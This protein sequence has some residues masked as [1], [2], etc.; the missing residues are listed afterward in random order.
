MH[1]ARLKLCPFIASSVVAV[2]FVAIAA[3]DARSSPTCPLS[4]GSTDAAKSHKLYLYF[5]TAPDSTFPNYGTNVSPA[6]AFNVA[7]LTSSIGTTAALRNRIFDVVSDDYCELNVQV[8]STT[9]NPANLASPPPRRAT[10][11]V[12]SDSNSNPTTGTTWG[13]AQ[14]TDTGDAVN[15]DFAR[16]WAGSYTVCEGSNPSGGCTTGSLTGSNATLDRW[17]QA[18]GGTSA[19][20]A[21]HTY[22]L[23]HTDDN[24]TTDSM[25][26]GPTPLA[27]EDSFHRHLMPSGNNLT[28]EDRASFRRHFSDRTFGLLATNVGLSIQTMHNWDLINSNAAA[29]RRLRIDF[30]SPLPSVNVAWTWT[31]A[32]SPWIAPTVS[33]PLGTSVFQGTTYNRF[34]ITWSTANPAWTGGS[35]GTVPGGGRFH[36]GATFT[37][38]DFNQPDPIIIQDITLLDAS[39]NPLILHP[40]LPIYDAGTVD[41]SDGTF[42]VNFAPPAGGGQLLIESAV[43][44]QLP[45]VASIQSMTGLGRPLTF[46]KAQIRPWS[47]STCRIK[48]LREKARCVIA[49]LTAKPHV[50]VVHRLG[51]KG[52]YDCSHGVPKVRHPAAAASSSD[53]QKP[54]DYEGPI[55]AGTQRDPF[56]STTVYM[57]VTVV[58][59]HAKYYDR[60]RKKYVVGRVT[61]KIYYQFAGIRHLV[62]RRS[63][64]ADNDSSSALVGPT[65]AFAVALLGLLLA[66]GLATAR[67]LRLSAHSAG[68]INVRASPWR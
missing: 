25:Q 51:Q 15:I 44:Y 36:I 46:D 49:T 8:L 54:L 68:T 60:K 4:Y 61:S 12:G 2:I 10:V 37:G 57:I 39:S 45:R 50:L 16:V 26:P 65:G 55:C 63:F 35:P 38:V 48:T 27:G 56:P 59:P 6:A 58:D 5:P 29:G 31:G 53:R 32:S 24:P 64:A 66:A 9:T 40:R 14:E 42:G 17:A 43:V 18:I 1:L 7:N 20:E 41:A 11:A 52:V 19:H 62:K 28:G 47:T 22:G 67:R 34:R 21:G 33:G 3:G 23:A 30:L 13:L